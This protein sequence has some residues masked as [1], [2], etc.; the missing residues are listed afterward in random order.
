MTALCQD[1]GRNTVSVGVGGGFP[2]GGENVFVTSTLPNSA[3]FSAAYEFR[4][5]KY[6]APEVGVV[7]LIPNIGSFSGHAPPTF[8]RT[9]VT[10]ISF[11]GR[12]IAP[13]LGGRIEL[14][15]GAAG[16]HASSS[17]S[18]LIGF[19]TT[20]WLAQVNG[21]GRIAIDK[22]HR[23]WL[24]PT[25]RFSRDVSRPTQEW[26]SLTADFGFRF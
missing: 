23:F 1:S 5:F 2:A 26:A 14:F 16:V 24:G 8:N 18:E 12:G 21:G 10:L 4:L 3:A 9:R 15:A 20:S 17:D 6:F 22:L 19:G 13:L 25:V 11:G 7:N